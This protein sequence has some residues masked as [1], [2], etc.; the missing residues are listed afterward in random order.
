MGQ[1]VSN[2]LGWVQARVDRVQTRKRLEKRVQKLGALHLH[3]TSKP[4]RLKKIQANPDLTPDVQ[5]ARFSL[6]DDQ[7]TSIYFEV[8][9]KYLNETVLYY[10]TGVYHEPSTLDPTN[11]QEIE[12]K[13][14]FLLG[15]W[16][17]CMALPWWQTKNSLSFGVQMSNFWSWPKVGLLF[18]LFWMNFGN[19]STLDSVN[20]LSNILVG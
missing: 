14:L 10:E 6:I 11:T 9:G 16:V 18:V 5:I 17:D 3:P 15:N 13:K 4:A 7:E 8:C 20:G 12:K 2:L 19:F 1:S